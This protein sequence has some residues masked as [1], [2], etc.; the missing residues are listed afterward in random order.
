MQRAHRTQPAGTTEETAA[1]ALD[2]PEP[3]LIRDPAGRLR[4][5]GFVADHHGTVLTS[6]QAV[7]GLTQVTVHTADGATRPVRGDALVPLPA[8]GLALLRTGGRPLG[9]PMPIAPRGAVAAGSY[10]RFDAGGPRQARVLGPA[11]VTYT[12]TEHFHRI[13]GVL[14]L[15]MGT[16]AG[17]A[18]RTTAGAGAPVLDPATGA[19]LAVLGGALHTGHRAA[20]FAVPLAP[21]AAADPH[22]PLA[23]L[24]A[25]NAATVPAYG[26]DL[27]LAGALHL[28]ATTAAAAALDADPPV[29]RR[30]LTRELDAFLASTAAVCA[31]TG[32]PGTGRSTELAA[33]AARRARGPAP[34][35]TLHLRGADLTGGATSLADAAARALRQAGRS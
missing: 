6:H 21:A 26:A 2:H 10:V 20:G 3:V 7:D 16:D 33:L 19:V 25:A 1:T 34:A 14:E 24:L 13:D 18:L 28:T 23:A 4:G 31:L 27:N 8:A 30:R 9:P 32:G 22:G 5:A 12:A 29:E 17:E 11:Q 35:P 15:A